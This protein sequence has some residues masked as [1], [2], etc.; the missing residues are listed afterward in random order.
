MLTITKK[1]IEEAPGGA[2]GKYV[3]L[4]PSLGIKLIYTKGE[5]YDD[6]RKFKGFRSISKAIQS[7][8]WREAN[9]EADFLFAAQ[10]SGV[11]PRCYGATVVLVGSRYHIGILMQ[12]LG[13]K[14][15]A[16]HENYDSVEVFNYLHDRLEDL[17]IYHGDLHEDNI[18]VYRGKYYAVDFSPYFVNMEDK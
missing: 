13:G 17:G 6:M 18:M 7:W 16:D 4:S 15:L 9:I 12:H 8:T 2:F 3:K 11:V 5:Y 14:A 1:Q 10:E